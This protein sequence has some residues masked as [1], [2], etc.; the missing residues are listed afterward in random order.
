[1]CVRDTFAGFPCAFN[2]RLRATRKTPKR[3]LRRMQR[4]VFEEVPRLAAAIAGGSRLAR[5]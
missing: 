2:Q 5:R 1:M 3:R 4:G